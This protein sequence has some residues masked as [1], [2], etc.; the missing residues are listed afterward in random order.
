MTFPEQKILD[1]GFVLT[2]WVL[3]GS[4]AVFLTVRVGVVYQSF[5]ECNREGGALTTCG[6]CLTPFC[7]F[8]YEYFCVVNK[9]VT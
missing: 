7:E 5:Q 9:C 3:K 2:L 1:V 8:L 4:A 6:N